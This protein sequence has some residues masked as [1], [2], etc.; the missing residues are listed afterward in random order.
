MIGKRAASKVLKRTVLFYVAVFLV[1]AAG[2]QEKIDPL[3]KYVKPITITA[4]KR[5]LSTTKYNNN[6]SE[7]NNNWTRFLK[8]QG[9]DVEYLWT[10]DQTQYENKLNI[11]I[12]SGD[13]PDVI[14]PCYTNQYNRLVA[15]DMLMDMKPYLDKYA[16]PET[17]KLLGDP[18]YSRI[19]NS[20]Q[21]NGKL[22]F[23]PCYAED[24]R[25][26]TPNLF[27]RADWLK[28]ANLAVPKTIDEFMK[29]CEAFTKIDPAKGTY[30]LAIDGKTNLIKDW[31]GLYGFFSMYK[32]QPGV[33]LFDNMLFYEKDSA[34]KVI[35]SGNKPGVVD[36]LKALQTMYK[37]GYLSRD[38]GTNDIVSDV[39]AGKAG[40]FFGAWW[41]SSWPLPDLRAKDPT[42]EWIVCS[43]PTVDGSRYRPVAFYN[44]GL[45]IVV[46]AKCKNPEAVVKMINWYTEKAYVHV[47]PSLTGLD[48]SDGSSLYENHPAFVRKSDLYPTMAQDI[49]A[50]VRS[51]D[52]SKLDASEKATYD[53]II[54][55]LADP[56]NPE[57]A[58]GWGNAYAY[59]NYLDGGAKQNWVTYKQEDLLVNEYFLPVT[60]EISKLLPIYK[61]LAEESI[62]KIIYG[63][64][65]AED[66]YKTVESWNK[67]GGNTM[68]GIV[69]ATKKK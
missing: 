43:P 3:G 40:M 12:A 20:V 4:V 22:F 15:G 55:Y 18:T 56:R 8:D 31:S 62:T 21:K 24:L 36:A 23:I 7:E 13:I 52:A 30:A 37:K 50:A 25:N 5:T 17:K 65:P 27:I 1:I 35:W 46:S 10:V 49:S 51:K 63:A 60:D 45:G 54:K 68:L 6:D 26:P 44:G 19:I 14:M 11:S 32:A 38:F 28:K 59:V 9:I 29:V 34:G 47:D 64:A 16:S 42:A 69:Q 57:N 61:K 58:P 66:W 33:S 41:C 67:Q 39:V 53:T 2:A 48:Y